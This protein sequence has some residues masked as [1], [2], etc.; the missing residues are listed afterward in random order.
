MALDFKK[1]KTE[2]H[3]ASCQEIMTTCANKYFL[4]V[5]LKYVSHIFPYHQ[6]ALTFGRIQIIQSIKSF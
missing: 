5:G 2:S 6:F 3:R 1:L 4:H